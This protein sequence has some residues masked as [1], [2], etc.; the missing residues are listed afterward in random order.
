MAI[1][2]LVLLANSV[3]AFFVRNPSETLFGEYSRKVKTF[4]YS[5]IAIGLIAA[6]FVLE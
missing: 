5:T 2:G 1:I 4:A 3:F 6:S